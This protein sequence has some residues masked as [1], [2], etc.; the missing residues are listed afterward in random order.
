MTSDSKESSKW[1]ESERAERE[2]TERKTRLQ[3]YVFVIRCISYPFNAKQPTDIT[4]RNLRLHR[5]QLEQIQSRVTSYLKEEAPKSGSEDHF[6]SAVQSFYEAVLSTD[7]LFML[8]KGGGCSIHDLKE[9]FRLEAKKRVKSL[10]DP[11]G[12]TKEGLINSWM[13]KFECLMRGD[14]DS[15][16]T[17]TPRF[18]MNLTPDSILTKD[19]LYDMFQGVIAIKKF[20]H[21][22]LFK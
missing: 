17:K 14:D 13:G 4:K 1:D 16:N 10:P 8:V 11:Q 12:V 6:Y 9:V 5:Q 19:Q 22:L 18:Q 20:E 15:K 21:Q 7:R 3:L 2:E